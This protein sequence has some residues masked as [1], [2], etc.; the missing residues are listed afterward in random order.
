MKKQIAETLSAEG[1]AT[2][3]RRIEDYWLR[4]GYLVTCRVERVVAVSEAGRLHENNAFA[5]RS[6]LVNGLPTRRLAITASN[7]RDWSSADNLDLSPIAGT[8][9]ATAC[10]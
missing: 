3:A 7:G 9:T 6:D 8:D 2:L 1:A 4:E 10:R 5:V